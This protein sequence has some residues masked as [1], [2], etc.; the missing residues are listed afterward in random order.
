MV[1]ADSGEKKGITRWA[2]IVTVEGDAKDGPTMALP[3]KCGLSKVE[4]VGRFTNLLNQK[5]VVI[6]LHDFDGVTGVRG[7]SR[8]D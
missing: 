7:D 6:L 3:N 4:V 2:A 1:S 8:M 5:A